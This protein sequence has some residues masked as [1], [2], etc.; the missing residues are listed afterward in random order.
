MWKRRLL[1]EAA[2]GGGHRA[3]WRGSRR[4]SQAC[5]ILASAWSSRSLPRSTGDR[6]TQRSE[7]RRPEVSLLGNRVWASVFKVTSIENRYPHTDARV[8][9][10]SHIW[11]HP[12]APSVGPAGPGVQDPGLLDLSGQ[13]RAGLCG[14]GGRS[15]T[16]TASPC[17]S[18]GRPA[19]VPG[20]RAV[21][22]WARR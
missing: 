6:H 3:C 16:A 2:G 9:A 14:S 7:G 5:E 17:E 21:C 11:G 12:R 18:C 19:P 8:P 1:P 13:H 4:S 20:G 10:E 15:P 22:C